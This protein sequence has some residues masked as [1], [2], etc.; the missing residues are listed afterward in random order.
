MAKKKPAKWLRVFIFQHFNLA[1]ETR[2][3]S[4][5]FLLNVSDKAC[6]KIEQSITER[7][8]AANN[9]GD[10][11]TELQVFTL[12]DILSEYQSTIG[13]ALRIKN[14]TEMKKFVRKEVKRLTHED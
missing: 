11:Y 7:L 3:I 13:P 14:L 9:G 8:E 12:P 4:N 6:Q 1:N 2:P 10:E 5:V